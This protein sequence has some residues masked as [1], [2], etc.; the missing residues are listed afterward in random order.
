M[1]QMIMINTDK[2]I[3]NHKNQRSIKKQNTDNYD[4]N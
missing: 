2:T 1:T 3:I 4:K